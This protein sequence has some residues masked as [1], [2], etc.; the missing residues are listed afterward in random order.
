MYTN[1][2]PK[3]L[4]RDFYELTLYLVRLDVSYGISYRAL[5]QC[6]QNAYFSSMISRNI[7][8]DFE[9]GI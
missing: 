5:M 6:C 2:I 9:G 1:A 3:K 4:S 8:R 7:K